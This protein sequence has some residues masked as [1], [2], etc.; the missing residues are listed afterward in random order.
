MLQ[1][2][3]CPIPPATRDRTASRASSR[4]LTGAAPGGQCNPNRE[5]TLV[6]E[7]IHDLQIRHP[8]SGG[9][10]RA[11]GWVAASPLSRMTCPRPSG[12][13]SRMGRSAWPRRRSRTMASR[14][15][16]GPCGLDD[17]QARVDGP[18]SLE[19]DLA[20]SRLT[21]IRDGDRAVVALARPTSAAT[22]MKRGAVSAPPGTRADSPGRLDRGP[23]RTGAGNAR[24]GDR[25]CD[26]GAD[27]PPTA[28]VASVFRPQ[29]GA[30]AWCSAAARTPE[31]KRS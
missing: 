3:R 29:P 4:C 31:P 2:H 21:V 18:A 13:C 1:Y 15:R 17:A 24:R 26:A 11:S 10:H 8:R 16:Y 23:R 7:S 14:K 27:G 28:E 19:K 20:R 6:E 12:T 25:R 22:S 5:S 30:S 9:P